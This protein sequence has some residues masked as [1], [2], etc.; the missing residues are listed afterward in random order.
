[1]RP[2]SRPLLLAKLTLTLAPTAPGV[3][4]HG[5]AGPSK[6]LARTL[7]GTSSPA[8]SSASS[9]A[10]T[11]VNDGS[12]AGAAKEVVEVSGGHRRGRSTENEAAAREARNEGG[13]EGEEQEAT[14]P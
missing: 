6:K 10:Q 14:Q 12:G 4:M 11:P 3:S 2:V 1:M 9:R 13:E 5:P 7:R 8:A